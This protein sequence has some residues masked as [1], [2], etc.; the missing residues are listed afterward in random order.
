MHLRNPFI[1]GRPARGEECIPRERQLQTVFNRLRNAESTAIIGDPHI[2]KTS[3]LFQLADPS[4]QK[5]YLASDD[6]KLLFANIDLHSIGDN[7]TPTDFWSDALIPLSKLNVKS[8]E[9]LVEKAKA[10]QYNRLSLEILFTKLE[11][12]NRVLVLLLDEFDRLLKHSNFKEPSFFA[13]LRSLSTRTGGLAVVP[14]SRISVAELNRLGRELLDAGS[15]FFNNMVDIKLPPFSD[16]EIDPLL[17]KATLQFSTGENIFIRRVAGRN[18][19]L[20]QAMAGTLHDTAMSSLRFEIAAES[21][22]NLAV[23]YFD[24]LWDYMDD[25]TRTIAV[26]LS[27]LDIGGRALGSDFNYGEIERVDM[28]GV[29]LRKLAERGLAEQIEKSTQGL[30]WDNKNLL[31]WRGERWS[32]GCTAFSWWVRDTLIATTR[33]IPTY[34]EWLKQKRYIGVIT[35]KQWDDSQRL[36]KMVPASMLK[37][38]GGLAK[39]LWDEITLK[40]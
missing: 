33:S 7:Y 30:I 26:I 22:Y 38:V 18:P 13:L 32:L 10:Y 3:F 14:A 19:F 2:G 5:D 8:I 20:L 31:I 35:Q 27:L 28:Y 29:E 37:G 25:N 16:K 9:N 24:D 17:A 40:K 11:S 39:S 34:N 21:F 4:I 1:Y 36:F 23:Q 12:Q 15:P 6:K